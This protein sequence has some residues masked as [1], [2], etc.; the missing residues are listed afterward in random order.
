MIELILSTPITNTF[1]YLPP[2][3]NEAPVFNA[4]RNP[5]HA[6]PKSNPNAFFAP[7]LSPIIFAVAGNTISGVTVAQIIQSISKGSSF[8][9]RRISST[10]FTAISELALPGSLKILLS[11]IPVL[12]RIHSSLVSTI[13]S[14]SKLVNF[15]SG[16]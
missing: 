1:L 15:V 13:F 14:R 10:A 12:V 11:E 3:I 4:K 8:F 9:L 7:I 16:T 6:A 2:S 5:L